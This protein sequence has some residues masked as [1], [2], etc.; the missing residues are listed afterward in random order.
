MRSNR[1]TIVPK[2]T[3]GEIEIYY[4]KT[5]AVDAGAKRP[6][7]LFIAG[8]GSDLRQRPSVFDGPLAGDFELLSYE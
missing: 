8:S 4:E 3:L 7:L 5:A 1:E 6:R 2:A